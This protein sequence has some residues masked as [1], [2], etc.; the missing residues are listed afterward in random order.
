MPASLRRR[1]PVALQNTRRRHCRGGAWAVEIH[2]SPPTAPTRNVAAP[3]STD[4]IRPSVSARPRKEN[5]TAMTVSRTP[6]PPIDIGTV[7]IMFA[8]RQRRNIDPDALSVLDL[9]RQYP[10][11]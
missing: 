2:T 10:S 5:A 6:Q 3:Y 8:L 4:T 9:P 1:P 7:V 11:D